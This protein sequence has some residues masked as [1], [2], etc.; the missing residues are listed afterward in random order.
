MVLDRVNSNFIKKK[1]YLVLIVFLIALSLSVIVLV[2]LQPKITG[3]TFGIPEETNFSKIEQNISEIVNTEEQNNLEDVQSENFEIE[4]RKEPAISEDKFA[5]KSDFKVHS[6]ALVPFLPDIPKNKE[7]RYLGYKHSNYSNIIISTKSEISCRI[8]PDGADDGWKNCSAVFEVQNLKNAKPNI[9]TPS[10]AFNHTNKNIRNTFIYFSNISNLI[11]ETYTEWV[12]ID[13]PD[14]EV[15]IG[16]SPPERVIGV[17]NISTFQKSNFTNFTSLP[18]V[19]VTSTPFAIKI[20]YQARKFSPNQFNLSINAAAFFG[21]VDPDQSACGTLDTNGGQYS[22]TQNVN[23][24]GTCFT[25]GANN[26][27]LDC[28]GYII[29]YSTD[30]TSGTYGIDGTGSYDNITIKG[31]NIFEGNASITGLRKHGIYFFNSDN[32]TIA[33]NNITVSGNLSIGISLNYS[34]YTNISFNIIN[35]TRKRRP[36]GTTAIN[37][38][39]ASHNTAADN[40]IFHNSSTEVINIWYNSNWNTIENNKINTSGSTAGLFK[41]VD[42]NYNTIYKNTLYGID[43]SG[44]HQLLRCSENNVSY[45][46][47]QTILGNRSHAMSISSNTEGHTINNKIS[48]NTI[49]TSG[50]QSQGFYIESGNNSILTSNNIST[51]FEGTKAQLVTLYESHAYDIFI[52]AGNATLINNTFQRDDIGFYAAGISET[53][54]WAP[55]GTIIVKWYTLINTSNYNREAL[56]D[57]NVT[58]YNR[59]YNLVENLTTNS[60]GIT[61]RLME[62]TEYTRN[63][64][65]TFYETPH[66]INASR[67]NYDDNFTTIN[68]TAESNPIDIMRTVYLPETSVP[69]VLISSSAGTD[70]YEGTSTTLTC[71][72]SDVNGVSTMSMTASGSSVCSGTSSCS[73]SITPGSGTVSVACSAQD[74]FG[75]AGSSTITIN[76]AKQ[77]S[78][79]TTTPTTTPAAP[80]EAAPTPTQEAIPQAPAIQ[81]ITPETAVS[82]GDIISLEAAAIEDFVTEPLDP[83]QEIVFGVQAEA[84]AQQEEAEET[85]TTLEQQVTGV[86]PIEETTAEVKGEVVALIKTE[87]GSRIT[88]KKG[89][90]KGK[91]LVGISLKNLKKENVN[92]KYEIVCKGQDCTDKPQ[93]DLSFTDLKEIKLPQTDITYPIPILPLISIILIIGYIS[94]F[95]WFVTHK[96]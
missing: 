22:L 33:F 15:D 50:A 23:T 67:I 38:Q 76:V 46:W 13:N 12:L 63:H 95:S 64:S 30:G 47:I 92:L 85:V 48:F 75:N 62:L 10:I 61:T 21:F 32:S 16:N 44:G 7:V 31:C 9:K 4:S 72:A 45:N 6:N 49:I 70:F 86:A 36:G 68:L 43:G 89:I 42:S 40:I 11:N 52:M 90:A 96:K 77:V 93:L 29:N 57:S 88:V 81:P 84:E 80:I 53:T 87:Q 82:A 8:K 28:K 24:S 34:N 59:T 27:L 25:I 54:A 74:T 55:N 26:V 17:E 73:G 78:S 71:T 58:T 91:T 3:M 51:T 69:S 19:I 18:S 5:I 41:C 65:N 35:S 37:M 66:R 56:K 79:P 20:E 1:V 2:L 39:Y 94:Y 14:S 83:V 60:A